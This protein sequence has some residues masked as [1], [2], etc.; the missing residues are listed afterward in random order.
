MDRPIARGC[1]HASPPSDVRRELD[2]VMVMR[3]HHLTTLSTAS[4]ESA[5]PLSVYAKVTTFD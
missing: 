5:L 2:L 3:L 1:R 4:P